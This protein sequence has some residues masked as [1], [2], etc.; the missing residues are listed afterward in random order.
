[1]RVTATT[2]GP[3][4]TNADTVVVGVFEGEDVAHDVQD[5]LLQG[6]IESGEAKR[7][8]R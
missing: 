7:G 6:L 4:E 5:G 8:F 3:R 2:Q 1:M